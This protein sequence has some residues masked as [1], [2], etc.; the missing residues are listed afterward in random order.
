[1]T[2]KVFP[3]ESELAGCQRINEAVDNLLNIGIEWGEQAVNSLSWLKA[4]YMR[5]VLSALYHNKVDR[6]TR[7]STFMQI[8]GGFYASYIYDSSFRGGILTFLV[9]KRCFLMYDTLRK[10]SAVL[11]FL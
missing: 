5:R 8:D 2:K 1:M 9:K 6:K 4:T 7:R 10:I 3:L 11:W